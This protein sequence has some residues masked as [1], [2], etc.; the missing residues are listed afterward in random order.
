MENMRHFNRRD[1]TKMWAAAPGSALVPR[2]RATLV[3]TPPWT[4]WRVLPGGGST[5][6]APAVGEIGGLLYVFVRGWNSGIYYNNVGISPDGTLTSG[7]FRE[8][9]GGGRTPSAPVAIEWDDLDDHNSLAVFVR[10]ESNR[11]KYIFYDHEHDTWKGWR[12]V[13][14]GGLTLSPP[15]VA[16]IGG[17][18]NV[19]VRDLNNGIQQNRTAPLSGSRWSGWREIPGDGHTPSAPAAAFGDGGPSSLSVVVRGFDDGIWE[20]V[21]S[22]PLFSW[23]LWR[24]VPGGLRTPDAPA[25]VVGRPRQAPPPVFARGFDNGI[26]YNLRGAGGVPAD[27]WMQFPGGGL[28]PSPPAAFDIYGSPGNFRYVFMRYFDNQIYYNYY[29]L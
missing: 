3:G 10:D 27:E 25:L 29:R 8:I 23:S 6:D 1:V 18:V 22:Y 28:T 26:Y 7:G 24:A 12:E 2:G 20:N 19:Y 21:L 16:W 13:P 14:G 9:P 4:G 15:A 17:T 11:I 5:I